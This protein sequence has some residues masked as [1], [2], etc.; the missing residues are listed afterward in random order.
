MNL[1]ELSKIF[2]PDFAEYDYQ[3]QYDL[4][5]LM[6]KTISIQPVIDFVVF[7]RSIRGINILLELGVKPDLIHKTIPKT[8]KDGAVETWAQWGVVEYFKIFGKPIPSVDQLIVVLPQLDMEVRIQDNWVITNTAELFLIFR[9][10][11]LRPKKLSLK[12]QNFQSLMI[13]DSSKLSNEQ[14]QIFIDAAQ[15]LLP[16]N[17]YNLTDLARYRILSNLNI[18]ILLNFYTEENQNLIY[19]ALAKIFPTKWWNEQKELPEYILVRAVWCDIITAI[20]NFIYYPLPTIILALRNNKQKIEQYFERFDICQLVGK[21]DA[22]LDSLVMLTPAIL[23]NQPVISGILDHYLVYETFTLEKTK[24]LIELYPILLPLFK[25]L[26]WSNINP[27]TPMNVD[28][29]AYEFLREQNK[30]EG[31][32]DYWWYFHKK[33]VP[34]DFQKIEELRK[35][36]DQYI[37]RWK[38]DPSSILLNMPPG[39]L[40]MAKRR[41]NNLPVKNT[42]N[43]LNQYTINL[44]LFME[45]TSDQQGVKVLRH[46]L[47]ACKL[48]F[49]LLPYAIMLFKDDPKAQELLI[50]A[51]KT[52]LNWSKYKHIKLPTIYQDM[53]RG[54]QLAHENYHDTR[55]R[56]SL[57]Y[58]FEQHGNPLVIYMNS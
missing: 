14:I 47:M 40:N 54:F 4:I 35:E 57:S 33:F 56:N 53:K 3:I 2:L 13:K 20:P 24:K 18:D 9:V 12:Y 55:V 32:T 31:M 51:H 21:L 43:E 26:Q 16:D 25:K 6:L 46:H 37:D 15:S 48:P 42:L 34:T 17:F 19:S 58:Y 22:I 7:S 39:L 8:S 28:M 29:D 5:K 10:L 49:A 11:I 27:T 30:D 23:N 41:K 36:L 1:T 52:N 38:I 45:Y 50:T 44:D